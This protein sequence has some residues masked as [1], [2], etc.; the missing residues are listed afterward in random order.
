MRRTGKGCLSYVIGD[1]ET[2]MVIDASL[3]PQ[4]YLDLA[5]QRGWQVSMVLDTHIHADHLSR[6]RQ[7]AERSG[8]RLVLPDQQ[9]VGFPFTAI[10][11]GEAVGSG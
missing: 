3:D 5:H 11:D 2:A 10:H 7:L 8:A 6:S 9:R 1:G 4:I